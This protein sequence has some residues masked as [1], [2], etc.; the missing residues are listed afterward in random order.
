MG[1][2]DIY[3][4]PSFAKLATTVPFLTNINFGANTGYINVPVGTYAI[5]AVPTGTVPISTTATLL[6]G[7]QISYASG[8][9]RTIVLIDQPLVSTPA[10]QTVILHDYDSPSTN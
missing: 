7:A 4:V 10:I 6:N 2:I 3:L 8:S 1:A 9:V 5:A